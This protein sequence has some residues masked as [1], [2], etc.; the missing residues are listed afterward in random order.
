MIRD[1]S[2]CIAIIKWASRHC[3]VNP[4]HVSTRLLSEND[5]GDLR[6][7][8]I[9]KKDLIP[10]IIVWRDNGMPDY[11]NGKFVPLRFEK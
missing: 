5:K 10:A 3:G 1:D 9:H 6:S 2:D 11:A 4:L 7:C 8:A